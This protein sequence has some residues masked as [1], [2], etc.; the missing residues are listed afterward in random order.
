MA[1]TQADYL[2]AVE[3]LERAMANGTLRVRFADGREVTYKSS[4]EL[5]E[6]IGYMQAKAAAAGGAKLPVARRTTFGRGL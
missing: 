4:A 2:A 6:D 5:K 1:M 3:T